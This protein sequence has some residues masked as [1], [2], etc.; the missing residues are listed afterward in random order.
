[1]RNL[2]KSSGPI[3]LLKQG[4]LDQ[5]TQDHVQAR[6]EYLQRWR[7]HK[8]FGQPLHVGEL[9]EL[10]LT[11]YVYFEKHILVFSV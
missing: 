10:I 2:W 3:L 8:L 1:M 6:F 4:H 11:L 9:E 5:A 7:L